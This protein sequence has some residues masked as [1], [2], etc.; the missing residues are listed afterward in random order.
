MGDVTMEQKSKK[1]FFASHAKSSAALV[2]VVIH[3]ILLVVAISFV[4]VSVITKDDKKFEAK[5]VNRPKM[6]LKKLQVPVNVKKKK[7]Q[8]PKLRKRIV[9]KPKM[10]KSMPDIKMPEISGV[11]GGLGSAAGSLGGGGGLGFTM[12]EIDI[13]GIKGKGE[14]IVLILNPDAKM[15]SDKMGGIPAYTI[16]KDELIRI[17]EELPPTA[18]FNVIVVGGRGDVLAF[19]QLVPANDINSAKLKEWLAPLNAVKKGMGDRDFGAHTIGPG[20][21]KSK[22]PM[23]IGKF[24]HTEKVKGVDKADTRNWSR[25]AMLAHKM[26]ADTIFVLT[27]EWDIQ[28]VATS[29]DF[30]SREEWNQTSAGKKWKEAHKEALRLLDEENARRRAAG[31]PPKA[32]KRGEWDMRREYYPGIE[33]PPGPKYYHYTP[34]D[35][36][37]AFILTRNEYSP[38]PLQSWLRTSRN[39]K[40]EFSFNVIQ[41][42]PE[43][44]SSG[45]ASE[46]LFKQL[47][48]LCNG[49]YQTIAGLSEIES[50]VPEKK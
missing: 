22:D 21:T 10:N 37:E 40:D 24:L 49:E 50:Y 35:F 5:P 1:G 13:F 30:M 27:N 44:F 32:I 34:R 16:I 17:V 20:G 18:L 38:A 36:M 3:A 14:K 41:F 43:G 6:Q 26:Q 29:D 47:V 45:G 8:K 31:L 28:R 15:M 39:I 42:I 48:G 19:P 12:P 4:A 46:R 25:A 9:V 2:S 7:T 23:H 11:K 33:A